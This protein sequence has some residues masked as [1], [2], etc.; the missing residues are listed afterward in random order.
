MTP[1]VSNDPERSRSWPIYLDA[2]ISKTVE[3]KRLGSNGTP[4]G[5]GIWRT[6]GHVT[7]TSC[8]TER[9]RSWQRQEETVNGV[10]RILST[11]KF[12]EEP[13]GSDI[14]GCHPGKIFK[15]AA[16]QSA[17]KNCRTAI[18]GKTATRRLISW[19]VLTSVIKAS[20]RRC[21]GIVMTSRDPN[22][23]LRM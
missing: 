5:R 7:M 10:C 22:C 3:D 11:G 14:C 6:I 2:N 21:R 1:G 13:A 18:V 16:W 4:V 19:I 17:S 15:S 20:S 8:D 23:Q 9:S 12:P